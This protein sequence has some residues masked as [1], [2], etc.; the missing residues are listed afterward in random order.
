[1]YRIT[2]LA[3]ALAGCA[4]THRPT[5]RNSGDDERPRFESSAPRPRSLAMRRAG[6][7]LVAVGSVLSVGAIIAGAAANPSGCHDET[8]WLGQMT[9]GVTLGALGGSLA[10]TGGGLAVAG[11]R[12]R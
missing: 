10:I 8:C 2:L 3:L 9:A 7:A 1:M 11:S 12:E 5:P 4:T 6:Y